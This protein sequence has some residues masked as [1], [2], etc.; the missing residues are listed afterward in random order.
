M[1]IIQRRLYFIGD[2]L[3]KCIDGTS[4]DITKK[5]CVCRFFDITLC[6]VRCLIPDDIQHDVSQWEGKEYDRCLHG[7]T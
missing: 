6:S 2:I 7:R 3:K 5:T 4:A 1:T